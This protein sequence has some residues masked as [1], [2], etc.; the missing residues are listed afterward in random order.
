M[1]FIECIVRK[2]KT[3]RHWKMFIKSLEELGTAHISINFLVLPSSSLSFLQLH[4]NI[5][6]T[7]QQI[8]LQHRAKFHS[9]IKQFLSIYQKSWCKPKVWTTQT[10][11]N[12]ILLTQCT[13]TLK[14]R[15]VPKHSCVFASAYVNRCYL[16]PWSSF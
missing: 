10:S 5:Q 13:N 16:I 6:F 7:F 14:L 9:F 3:F 1:I 15:S 11:L 12:K 4:W 8:H 2:L